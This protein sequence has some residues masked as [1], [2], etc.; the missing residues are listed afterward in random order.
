MHFSALISFPLTLALTSLSLSFLQEEAARKYGPFDLVLDC[1]AELSEVTSPKIG[2]VEITQTGEMK[3]R[4]RWEENKLDFPVISVD[5]SKT[6]RLEDAFGSADGL[7]RALNQVP[8][9][10]L[11]LLPLP[12]HPFPM[13]ALLLTYLFFQLLPSSV[14]L[15]SQHF[16]VVGFGKVGVG[17]CARLRALP[18]TSVSV[19]EATTDAL[20][21]AK[22]AG[23]NVYNMR[24]NLDQL[25]PVIKN[26][27][28]ILTGQCLLLFAHVLLRYSCFSLFAN[29]NLSLPFTSYRQSKCHRFHLF[30]LSF[31]Y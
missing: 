11:L 13:V 19:F 9:F 7:L 29:H 12:L 3:L 18:G 21:R 31:S 10:R 14:S 27:F 15:S 16:I 23:Y 6:K 25:L 4:K 8:S 5:A 22:R 24:E 28:M 17:V 2:L 30:V 26:T 20:L 1:C